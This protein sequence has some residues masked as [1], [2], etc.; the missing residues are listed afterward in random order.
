MLLLCKSNQK[1]FA[2]ER[3]Y[4]YINTEKLQND[5]LFNLQRREKKKKKTFYQLLPLINNILFEIHIFRA[6]LNRT[7]VQ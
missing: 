7:S 5:G 6:I 3:P 4:A 2:F 1:H